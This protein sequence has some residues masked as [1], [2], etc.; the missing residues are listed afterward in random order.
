[1][2]SRILHNL[3]KKFRFSGTNVLIILSLFVGMATAFGALGFIFL[4]RNFNDIFFG[5]SD[6]ILTETIGERGY[7]YWLPVIPMLG[8][9][10]VGPIIYKKPKGTGCRK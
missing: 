3:S 5:L 2:A 1:M 10:L 4:I 9:L 6:Q 8:G 7:K